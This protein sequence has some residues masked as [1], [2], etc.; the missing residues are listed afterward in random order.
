MRNFNF[1]NTNM[2]I[3]VIADAGIMAAVDFPMQNFRYNL[4]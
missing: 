1:V 4:S 3:D 2:N